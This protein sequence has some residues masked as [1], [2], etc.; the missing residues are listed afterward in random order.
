[1]SKQSDTFESLKSNQITVVNSGSID[2]GSGNI[3]VEGI[4]FT[5]TINSNT[6]T[7]AT[8]FSNTRTILSG[9]SNIV[10]VNTG[11]FSSAG[12]FHFSGTG[13]IAW[14]PT[15]LNAGVPTLTNRSIG[16]RI[17]IA[18][19]I[20]G[21]NYDFGIGYAPDTIWYTTR[22]SSCFHDFYIG[23]TKTV[24]ILTTG[25][26]VL[27]TTVS[28]SVTTGS[29][30]FGGGIGVNGA[31]YGLNIFSNGT[32]LKPSPLTT[33]GDLF[34]RDATVDISLPVGTNGQVLTANSATSSGLT[35]TTPLSNPLTTKGDIFTRDAAVVTRLP[36]GTNGQVL[37]AN[38]ATATGLE[39]ITSSGS[40]PLT[41]KGDIFTRNATVVD[42]LPVG[43]QGQ[44]L[45]TSLE[46]STGLKWVD[47]FNPG[48]DCE[49]SNFGTATTAIGVSYTDIQT[50]Q[51]RNFD[52]RGILNRLTNTDTIINQTGKYL[53][54]AVV[55][56]TKTVGT[57]STTC[58]LKMV[59]DT[60][61]TLT[62]AFTD[63]TNVTSY[64]YNPNVTQ[65]TDTGY[66]I[67][68]KNY[69]KN[70]RI[71]IQAIKSIGTGDTI[72]QLNFGVSLNI[73][74][75]C[76]D[77]YQDNTQYFNAYT[78]ANS[79]ALTGSFADI[80]LN[81]SR[82]TDSNYTFT[83][84]SA[85]VTLTT[86]GTYF[87]IMNC[88]ITKSSGVD[89]S[90]A[91]FQ[92]VKN[93]TVIS[94][95]N[96]CAFVINATNNL[97]S[98]CSQVIFTAA[99]NDTLKIQGQLTSGSNL[100]C[101]PGTN[102]IIIKLQNSSSS[103][104]NTKYL[105]L[106]QTANTLLNTS[107]TDIP[108]VTENFKT[109][110]AFTHSTVTN[111][112]EITITEDGF[113]YLFGSI[114][115]TNSNAS[116]GTARMLFLYNSSSFYNQ[117]E[118]CYSEAYVHRTGTFN[119]KTFSNCIFVYIPSGFI[120]KL[121]A[122]RTSTT[123]VITTQGVDTSLIALKANGPDILFEPTNPFGTY[124][125]SNS[126]NVSTLTA[127]TTFV[128]KLLLSTGLIPNGIYRLDW[129][130][131]L[132]SVVANEMEV[133]ILLNNS[134]QIMLQRI[135]QSV[136]TNTRIQSGYN[137]LT[138]ISRNYNIQFDFRSVDGTNVIIREVSFV[139]YRIN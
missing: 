133:Q 115:M 128:Q 4:V 73:A 125:S 22:D 101:S 90:M 52:S 24:Q 75:F 2:I 10:S 132:A 96:T 71:K 65:P 62:G 86:A 120:I 95:T 15:L 57:T 136:T 72:T 127:S 137:L 36:V 80:T 111:T 76:V 47:N 105:A 97:G 93:A 41:V 30:I 7:A 31:I 28:T 17:I 138:L 32:Q 53:V 113:Y 56:L 6:S 87:A 1:M 84:G 104:V 124:F 38:S 33:K 26:K 99:A 116:P 37:T 107:T 42:R 64:T 14:N 103:Q 39:W 122:L 67:Y 63:V 109:V 40:N 12:D 100:V 131:K 58:T 126:S 34:T 69:N 66:L 50:E 82:I 81:A 117:Y 23:T 74:S 108:Y 27:S 19:T 44:V 134:N 130:F 5:D 20:S 48:I 121:Q 94:G 13:S 83:P 55:A 8:A 61:G 98:T 18:P 135:T 88:N 114:T 139:F 21:T 29:G 79:A 51:V 78:N 106:A 129:S 118:G 70:D 25:L 89:A 46:T 16:S 77:T 119:K 59:E 91:T 123:G 54:V 11:S 85:T 43:T 3:E 35:W 110:S 112:Q 45:R 68:V 102:L 49:I 9:T 60:S 92:F